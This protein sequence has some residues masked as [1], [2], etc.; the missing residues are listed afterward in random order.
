MHK[1]RVDKDELRNQAHGSM[2]GMVA[3]HVD[4]VQSP[5]LQWVGPKEGKRGNDE[6]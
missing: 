6:I 5:G 1:S 4:V 3:V 2:Q